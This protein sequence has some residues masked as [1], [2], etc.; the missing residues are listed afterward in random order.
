VYLEFGGEK[1]GVMV[2]SLNYTTRQVAVGVVKPL[3]TGGK[4][5]EET[6]WERGI[7]GEGGGRAVRRNAG[8]VEGGGK[9]RAVRKDTVGT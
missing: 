4:W 8:G 3:D 1:D 2:K 6:E 9:V 7:Y 5:P